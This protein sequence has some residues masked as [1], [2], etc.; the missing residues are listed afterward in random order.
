VFVGF[1]SRLIERID[2]EGYGALR[3]AYPEVIYYLQRRNFFRVTV[4]PGDISTVDIQRRGAKP[5]YGQCHDISV[6]G[7]R[8]IVPSTVDFALTVGEY[9]PLVRF[10][11]EDIELAV[12]AEV[13]FVGSLR[14]TRTRQPVRQIG[15]QFLNLSPGFE[16]RLQSYVQKRD[17][18][19]LRESR[20]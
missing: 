1:Q 18:E 17:R 20:R 9:I 11:L 8:L 12:E 16:Q 6:N 10:S 7:M 15:I 19:L 4:G 3:I 5:L 13:R 2:Y 14:D